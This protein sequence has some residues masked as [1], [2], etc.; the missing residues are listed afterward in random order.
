MTAVAIDHLLKAWSD[1]IGV[2]V[3]YVY[4]NYKAQIDQNVADLLA[5]ILKQLVQARPS[6]AEPVE[7]LHKHHAKK[8]TKP[9]LEEIFKA[10]Q[11]VLKNYSSV[12]FAID[13]LDEC[14]NRATRRQFLA[15]LRDLQRGTDLRLLATSR[16][17]PDIVDEFDEALMLEVRAS[18]GDVKQFVAGQTYLL[19]NCIQRDDTLQ[20][21]VQDKIVQA[22]D[23]M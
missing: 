1:T 7:H 22:V 19:P 5:A 15:K 6:I 8:G 23:G 2:G 11:S 14:S 20:E 18:D 17:I 12:Y 10:L 16:W 9:S 21:M 3:V 13:A 4:C